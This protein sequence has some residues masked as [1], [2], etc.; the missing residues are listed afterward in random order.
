MLQ[1]I[2]LTTIRAIITLSGH[3]RGEENTEVTRIPRQTTLDSQHN[4]NIQVI[5]EVKRSDQV[6]D[7]GT[8]TT[9]QM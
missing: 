7:R 1:T 2:Q 9:W 5:T 8:P 6:V 3:H 4:H